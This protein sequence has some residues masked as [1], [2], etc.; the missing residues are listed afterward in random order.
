MMAYADPFLRGHWTF[1]AVVAVLFAVF[2]AVVIPL[3]VRSQVRKPDTGTEGMVGSTG[4]AVTDIH[5]VGKVRVVGELWDARSDLPVRKGDRVVVRGIDAEGMT[6]VVAP[7]RS[8]S[9]EPL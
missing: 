1:L 3:V 5:G 7:K 9:G 2:C 4:I 8:G 6:L